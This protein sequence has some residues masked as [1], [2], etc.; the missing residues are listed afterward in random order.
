MSI[1]ERGRNEGRKKEIKGE[2]EET[3]KRIPITVATLSEMRALTRT[4]LRF[5]GWNSTHM[6]EFFYAVLSSTI[7]RRLAT[8][9]LPPDVKGSKRWYKIRI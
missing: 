3:K 2:K 7:G 8:P 9:H 5:L 4:L 6:S 1:C